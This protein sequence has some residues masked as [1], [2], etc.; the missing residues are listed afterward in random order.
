MAKKSGKQTNVSQGLADFARDY[1]DHGVEDRT[2]M[3]GAD[4]R[5]I[6]HALLLGAI[7]SATGGGAAILFGTDR[8]QFLYA[9]TL[10]V[11]GQSI[12][13]YFHPEREVELLEDFLRRIID[14]AEVL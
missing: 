10:Y 9:V 3:V 14:T 11:S 7:Y 1:G 5:T 2:N 6:D 12:R 13:K 8:S 4:W